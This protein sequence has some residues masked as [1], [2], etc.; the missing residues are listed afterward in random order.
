MKDSFKI[1]E[2]FSTQYNQVQSINFRING[3]IMKRLHLIEEARDI[4]CFGKLIKSLLLLLL[5]FLL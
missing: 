4:E 2:I 3:P 1:S 5:L